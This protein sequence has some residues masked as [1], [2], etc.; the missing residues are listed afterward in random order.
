[1][2]TLENNKKRLEELQDQLSA[3][4]IHTRDDD[5]LRLKLQK[6]SVK[7]AE[8]TLKLRKQMYERG[9]RGGLVGR[10]P[11][12]SE[13]MPAPRPLLPKKELKKKKVDPR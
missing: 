9:E 11:N 7:L 13:P 12:N 5:K 8:E 1:M 2:E 4:R 3:L 10:P 6:E